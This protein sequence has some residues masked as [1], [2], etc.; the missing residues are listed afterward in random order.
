MS[1]AAANAAS[2]NGH[3]RRGVSRSVARVMPAG[4]K[5]DAAEFGAVRYRYVACATSA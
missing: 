5:N 1:S 3:V 4:G 2:H